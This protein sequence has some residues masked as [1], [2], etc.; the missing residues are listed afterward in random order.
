VTIVTFACDGIFARLVNA[1][2]VP[3]GTEVEYMTQHFVLG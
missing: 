2:A 1:P 3:N